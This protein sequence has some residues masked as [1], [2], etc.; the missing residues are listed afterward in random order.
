MLLQIV[1]L[2]QNKEFNRGLRGWARMEED[3]G[4]IRAHP[5]NPR[6]PLLLLKFLSNH[7]T[8]E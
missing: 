8:H 2:C 1:R 3:F 5:R 4:L 7:E 6:L